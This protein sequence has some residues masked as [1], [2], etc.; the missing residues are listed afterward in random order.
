MAPDAVMLVELP[1]Q[2]DDDVADTETV[3]LGLTVIAT[4]LVLLQP[5]LEPVTEYVV[6]TVGFA[7]T[8]EPV[9]GLNP[10]VGGETQV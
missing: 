10:P 4:V 8:V 6:V 9:V 7:V 2:I 3:G 5:P 1:E